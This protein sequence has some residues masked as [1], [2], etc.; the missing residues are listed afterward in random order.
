MSTQVGQSYLSHSDFSKLFKLEFLP[1]A[2]TV[3][4]LAPLDR[5]R[6]LMQTMKMI[7]MNEHDKVYKANRLTVSKIKL[8]FRNRERAGTVF[9][10]ERKPC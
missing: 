2:L 8:T 6:N 10:V 4:V 1:I 3:T 9:L 7:S 5:L